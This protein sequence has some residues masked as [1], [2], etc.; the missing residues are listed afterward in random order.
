MANVKITGLPPA[1]LPLFGTE[2][3]E[4]VQGGDS[5]KVA[6]TD[7]ANTAN[8]VRTVPTGGTGASAL[9]GYV[10]GNGTSAMTATATVPWADVA[11]KPT[12]YG[13]F[14]DTTIQ[15]AAINTATV[16]LFNSTSLV[17]GV[18]MVGGSRVTVPMAG[19]YNFQFSAQL[20]N[21]SAADI[22]V[23]IWIRLNGL[24]NIANSCGDVTV[25]KKDGAI[26]GYNMAAWNYMES[27]AAGDYLEFMWST[28]STSAYIEALAARTAPTRPAAPSIILTVDQVA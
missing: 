19:V 24:T 18:T 10:K 15:T 13:A 1:T 20:V 14:Y 26:N 12:N 5:K 7:I 17:D 16:M 11:N 25:P 3:F 2:L 28:P 4:V 8:N 23:S 21:T 6:A 22:P 27:L 9:T